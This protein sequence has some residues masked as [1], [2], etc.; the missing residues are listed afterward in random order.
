[1]LGGMPCLA[2]GPVGSIIAL[3]ELVGSFPIFIAF[4]SG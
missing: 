2:H 3:V 4:S 1:M